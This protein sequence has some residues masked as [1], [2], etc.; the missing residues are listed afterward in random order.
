MVQDLVL[1]DFSKDAPVIKG[2]DSHL[3]QIE[4]SVV[5]S[6]VGTEP[7]WE[8]LKRLVIEGWCGKEVNNVGIMLASCSD[9]KSHHSAII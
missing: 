9:A 4:V 1:L 5:T 6:E 2:D 7:V 8:Q 3:K